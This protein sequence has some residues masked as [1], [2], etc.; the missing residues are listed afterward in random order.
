METVTTA[1]AQPTDAEVID[2]W[3]DMALGCVACDGTVDADALRAVEFA[4]DMAYLRTFIARVS[5]DYQDRGRACFDYMIA[6]VRCPNAI[7]SGKLSFLN[8]AEVPIG[9]NAWRARC[10]SDRAD[11]P[12]WDLLPSGPDSLLLRGSDV[13]AA[14]IAMTSIGRAC[15]FESATWEGWCTAHTDS[16]LHRISSALPLRATPWDLSAVD[17]EVGLARALLGLIEARHR[18]VATA[19]L[20]DRTVARLNTADAAAYRAAVALWDRH[21]L[22][23]NDKEDSRQSLRNYRPVDGLVAFVA[24]AERMQATP[25]FYLT[26]VAPAIAARLQPRLDALADSRLSTGTDSAR[27]DDGNDC[28]ADDDNSTP[29]ARDAS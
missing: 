22:V 5:K 21:A 25:G 20:S 11:N 2:Q 24:A 12:S 9:S 17:Q 4:C 29:D 15:P 19:R 1:T 28:G 13:V 8:I 18:H 7:K 6:G 10:G 14:L 26:F 23:L 16:W 27:K 3:I